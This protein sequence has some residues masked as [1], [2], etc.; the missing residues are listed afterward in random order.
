MVKL[1]LAVLFITYALAEECRDYNSMCSIYARF[2]FCK[3]DRK[4]IT[5]CRKSCGLCEDTV[6]TSGQT[7]HGQ[8][9]L[10][11][12]QDSRII[13]GSK[14]VKDAWP[15]QVSL[16]YNGQFMC[17]GSIL[18]SRWIL[19]AAHC[20]DGFDHRRYTVILGDFD[21]QFQDGDE[22]IY[23]AVRAFHHPDWMRPSQLNHD[24]ALIELDRPAK[25]NAHVQPIC[26]P[27]KGEQVPVGKKC[28]IT[29]WGQ[30]TIGQGGPPA[31]VLK[32]SPLNVVSKSKC[33]NLNTRKMGIKVT[34]EMLC[35]GYGPNYPNSGCHGDSGGP[36]VC[37]DNGK[38][39]LQ[40]SVS[41]GSGYCDTS[42][43]YTV[44]ARMSQFIDWINSYIN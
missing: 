21:R 33:T 36:F 43:G 37:Q 13:S 41:W 12:K 39:V 9:G 26:L 29:G 11:M 3:S 5:N 25:F 34:D 27:K 24:I 42:E 40:G 17:G 6:P 22:Q 14:A 18:N 1:I 23:D 31:Q 15:W 4:M 30:Y 44:F 2:G 19:T 28:Y 35:A 8:C 10:S 20:V 32:Q 7:S 38:W 16:Y